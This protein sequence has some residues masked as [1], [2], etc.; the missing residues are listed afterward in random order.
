M[1]DGKGNGGRAGD[2]F[3]VSDLLEIGAHGKGQLE[4][5]VVEDEQRN[6]QPRGRHQPVE[7][8]NR[9]QPGV[10]DDQRPPFAKPLDEP[11]DQRRKGHVQHFIEQQQGDHI[12]D[13]DVEFFDQQ[14]TGEDGENLPPRA[15]DKGQRVVKP[16]PPS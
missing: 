12:F 4:E 5:Q 1:V 8:E 2:V 16:V 9:D 3:R 10:L 11:P 7:D 15:G 14:H 13:V 6:G